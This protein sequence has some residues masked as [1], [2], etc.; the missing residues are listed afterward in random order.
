M[1]RSEGKRSIHVPELQWNPP[2]KQ[3]VIEVIVISASDFQYKRN[4]K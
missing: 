1:G 3:A 4:E 2:L